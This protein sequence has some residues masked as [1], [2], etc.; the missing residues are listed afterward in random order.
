VFCALRF[1]IDGLLEEAQ[2]KGVEINQIIFKVK[3]K[4]SYCCLTNIFYRVT[5]HPANSGILE[6][7]L[8]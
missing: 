4:S 8:A 6:W 3:K 7:S 5:G 2:K 1:V